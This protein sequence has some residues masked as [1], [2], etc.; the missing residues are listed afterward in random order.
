[1]VV[2]GR[3]VDVGRL[4]LL[5]DVACVLLFLL[6]L[7]AFD[8]LILL[9]LLFLLLQLAFVLINLLVFCGYQLLLLIIGLGLLLESRGLCPKVDILRRIVHQELLVFRLLLLFS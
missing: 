1:M 2:Q 7:L 8:S 6:L 3:D 5:L 9:L 4:V